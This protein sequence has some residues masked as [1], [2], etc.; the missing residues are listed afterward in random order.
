MW[1]VDHKEGWVLKNWCFQTVVLEK[2]PEIPLDCKDIRQVNPKW[3]QPWIF[4]GKTYAEAPILWPPDWK[5][6]L[7]GNDHNAGKYRT[8]KEKGVGQ[9]QM[10]KWLDA[11]LTQWAWIWANFGRWW[12]TGKP[13]VLQ[14]MGLQR[15]GHETEQPQNILTLY[16]P[17]L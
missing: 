17:F 2:T 6:Q 10:M 15:V 1:E 13:S 3:N 9:G 8:Q 5:N 4:I 7:T 11:S 16:F 12:R 14:C